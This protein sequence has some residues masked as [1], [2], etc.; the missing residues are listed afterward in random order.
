MIKVISFDLQGTL[1]DSAFSDE[2]WQETLPILYA[3]VHGMTCEEAKDVLKKQF[4]EWGVYDYRYYSLNY[5]L[6]ALQQESLSGIEKRMKHTPLFFPDSIALLKELQGKTTVIVTSSTEK[7]FI[8]REL[9]ENRKYFSAV[10]SSI[11]DF[12][13][14]GKPVELYLKIAR[15]LHVQ[16]GEMLHIGDSEEMDIDNAKK[17]GLQTFFFDKNLPRAEVMVSLK[18]RL[19]IP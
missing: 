16:P 5:W 2:F 10:Y 6:S 18:K 11:D 19:Q 8:N 14:A 4:A 1:S 7:E 9:G 15:M 3:V 12:G 13:I 17:A